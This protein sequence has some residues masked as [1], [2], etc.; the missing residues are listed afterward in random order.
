MLEHLNGWAGD[1]LR[2]G[3]TDA[4]RIPGDNKNGRTVVKFCAE[5]GLHVEDNTYFEQFA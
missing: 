1:K 5:K 2:T 4:F 3:I